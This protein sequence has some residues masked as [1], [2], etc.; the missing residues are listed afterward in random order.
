VLDSYSRMRHDPSPGISMPP[1]ERRLTTRSFRNRYLMRSATVATWIRWVR[2]NAIRSGRRAISPSGFMIS[3]ITPDGLSPA[4]RAR[5]TEPSVWP[6][7]SSTPPSRARS[8]NMCPG[9]TMSRGPAVGSMAT[10]TVCARSAAEI[11]VV[12]PS[13]ASMLT[14]NAVLNTL[15]LWLAIIGSPSRNTCPRSA[16]G[17]S[18]P[19]RGWP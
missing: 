7:R 11:P 6:T 8:G 16:T 17:R 10:F 2:P 5:S 12:T 15:V 13:R 18:G 4:S 3:Q 1:S 14:V 19:A 9:T